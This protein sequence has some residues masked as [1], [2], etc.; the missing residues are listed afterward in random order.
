MKKNVL[1]IWTLIPVLTLLA[2]SLPASAQ[3]TI[4]TENF[5]GT[6]STVN[7]PAGWTIEFRGDTSSNDWHRAP[8][9]GFNPWS[10][11][12]TPYAVLGTGSEEEIDD[13][14]ITPYLDFTGCYNITLR[15]S[16]GIQP[17]TGISD[18]RIYGAVDS[19]QFTIEIA[20]LTGRTIE[21]GLV[22]YD[23][24]W[25]TN[26]RGVRIAFAC[27]GEST[28]IQWFVIDN[29]TITAD[30]R[31]TDVGIRRIL[32]PAD[33]VDSASS[34][35]PACRVYNPSNGTAS[36]WTICEIG[37]AYRD[38]FY[39]TNLNAGD[40][41]TVTFRSWRADTAGIVTVRFQTRLPDD[42]N[43][44]NDT[45]SR[46][47]FVKPPFYNDVAAI[48]ILAPAGVVM[49]TT[50]VIPRGVIANL[51]PQAV[52]LK[53]WFEISFFGSP[54]YTDSVTHRLN[55][56][57]TDTISF[58][59]W[60]ATPAGTFTTTLWVS[61]TRDL[62]PDNDRINS[63][64]IVRT[65]SHDVGVTAILSP[66]DT[67]PPGPLTPQVQIVNFGTFT[68]AN[69]KAFFSVLQG[70]TPV[71]TDSAVITTIAPGE[72][73]LFTFRT[74]N[75]GRGT[76]T[77]ACSTRLT[78]DNEPYNDRFSKTVWVR[79]LLHPGWQELTPLPTG[80]SGKPVK[81]GG[82]IA[83]LGG[84]VYVLRGNKTNDFLAYDIE[85][86]SWF[87]LDNIPPGTANK[88]VYKGGALCADGIRYLYATKGYSTFG[89]F[90]Y[91]AWLDT[92]ESRKDVPP[93]PTGKPLKGGTKMAYV[94]TPQGDFVYLL[95]GYKNEFWRYNVIADSW[96]A[97]PE[98]PLGPSGKNSYKEGS[99]IVYDGTGTIYT[100][101][102]KYGE[103]FAFD[104]NSGQW[105]TTSFR[106]FPE[107]GMLGKKKKVKDG[108]GGAWWNGAMYCLKGG[109]TCEFWRFNPSLPEPWTELDTI[110]QLGTTGKKKR[111]KSGGGIT[112]MG[113]GIFF[114]LKGNK[115]V[116]FWCY[117]SPEAGPGVA[118]P[119]AP[120]PVTAPFRLE[121]YPNPTTGRVNIRLNTPLPGTAVFT[122]SDLTGRIRQKMVTSSSS[123]TLDLHRLPPGI[124]FV[125]AQQAG[126]K[127]TAKLLV[128]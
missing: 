14:L 107:A 40:S 103:V 98:A 61:A 26:R 51:A 75:A 76:Y 23:L 56:N 5:N 6:W 49:E 96:E 118:E 8:D 65:P 20:D 19:G 88:T 116:E 66:A 128:R 7:P 57:Q 79:T 3:Q 2:L 119:P 42:L 112:G 80:T 122:I 111:V 86:D 95:K 92:W 100:V 89:F 32:A 34:V 16:L 44:E 127:T 39:V 83:L 69:F 11:N 37:T 77:V 10:A 4:I 78:G 91:D 35:N 99:F 115:T 63:T 47:V 30:R 53:A 71:F 17:G 54:L 15:C 126:K 46:R 58:S 73:A 82:A 31:A 36:F 114:A 87:V 29:F 33:T 101:K 120:L 72:T 55:P 28:A 18:V 81:D 68:E 67:V 97:Q 93:G 84:K 21:P 106:N 25:A 13:W 48:A 9:L 109:N 24:G 70:T 52:N 62:N 27:L 50:T 105:L 90:R 64:V 1:Q 12:P 125:Q 113:N 117:K 74:W 108:A 104:V 121:L 45:A 85:Q 60:L 102:A 59:S 41:A 94:R 22:T 123:L 110:P 38:S 43:P 124:Y